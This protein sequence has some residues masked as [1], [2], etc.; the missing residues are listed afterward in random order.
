LLLSSLLDKADRELETRLDENRYDESQLISIK[1]PVTHLSY[2]N[3]SDQFERVDGNI[4]VGGV[5][6]KYVKRRIFNDS[7][8]VLCIPNHTAM[9]LQAMKRQGSHP[10]SSKIP[11]PE[12]YVFTAP[13]SL[14]PSRYSLLTIAYHY[15]VF[16]PCP[17]LTTDERP[18]SR[19]V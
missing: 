14:P 8:E 2:Y 13:F 17:S 11:A 10:A 5:Q 9:Q 4:E 1:V 7:L 3:T 19:M 12:P 15:S 6:Y 16:I 18:P